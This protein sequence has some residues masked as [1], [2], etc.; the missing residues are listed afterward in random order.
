MIDH[1]P[2]LNHHQSSTHPSCCPCAARTSRSGASRRASSPSTARARPPRARSAA[3]SCRCLFCVFLFVVDDD[4]CVACVRV[5]ARA[6]AKTAAACASERHL[7]ALASLLP[8]S[9]TRADATGFTLVQHTLTVVLAGL[10]ELQ[11]RLDDVDR[12]QARR[13]HHAAH[14]AFEWCVC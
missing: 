1:Q 14:R 4:G 6:C 9:K 11:A 10:V 3:R 2:H 5:G 13:L 8:S 7:R 12:L